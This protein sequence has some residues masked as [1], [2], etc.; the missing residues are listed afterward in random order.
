MKIAKD[1]DITI[2]EGEDQTT[3]SLIQML[4]E[5]EEDVINK[6]KRKKKKVVIEKKLVQKEAGKRKL[7]MS[8]GEVE[9]PKQTK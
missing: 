5:E 8:R 2:H 9:K 1:D 3:K 7:V 6:K 4:Q